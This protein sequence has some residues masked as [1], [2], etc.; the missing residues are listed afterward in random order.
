MIGNVLR[1]LKRP[2][3]TAVTAAAALATM[4]GV[5]QVS[6][7][8][9]LSNAKAPLDGYQGEIRTFAGK[10]LT[11]ARES[12]GDSVPIHQYR[13]EGLYSQRFTR[14]PRLL[15][16]KTFANKCLTVR[17]ESRDDNVPIDQYRC[18]D[19]YSQRF[20]LEW[21][22]MDQSGHDH[23]ALRTFADKCLTVQNDSTGDSV[24]IVQHR[25]TGAPSQ[26]FTFNPPL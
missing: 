9:G 4:M 20:R 5:P 14:Y 23:Y 8:P 7:A 10:C 11:V 18:V 15:E 22:S 17:N 2:A 3:V 26:R 19:L 6:A 24:P 25:C 12:S 16:I 21:V 1:S 13:C